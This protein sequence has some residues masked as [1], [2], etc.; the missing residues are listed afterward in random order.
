MSTGDKNDPIPFTFK[1]ASAVLT[2]P[3]V[4]P[5]L[6]RPYK[7]NSKDWDIPYLAGYS[8]DASMIY[9]DR[10]LGHWPRGL[11][12]PFLI[13]HEHDEKSLADAIATLQG[14]ALRQ[15][16]N[17]LRMAHNYDRIYYHCHGV[18]TA[19]EEHAV[20]LKYGTKGVDSYNAFMR[21]QIKRA[22][23]ER[24]R[25]VPLNI[26]MLPYQGSDAEDVRL[27]R[28]MEAHMVEAA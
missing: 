7:I 21:G 23:D 25:R 4:V 9:L 27:R 5:F 14:A 6:R 28:V 10:D 12:R 22:E 2:L 13:E 17:M 8:Q 11:T 16:L 26:D 1:E 15:L 18:A 19:M 24:I 20:W 3:Q